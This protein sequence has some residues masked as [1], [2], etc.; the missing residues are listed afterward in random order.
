MQSHYSMIVG[1]GVVTIW[2]SIGEH[3]EVHYSSLV[4]RSYVFY[5]ACPKV[6]DK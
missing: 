2:K 1:A 5:P 6:N 4:C 3:G